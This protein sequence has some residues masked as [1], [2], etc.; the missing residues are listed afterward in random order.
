MDHCTKECRNF[1]ASFER[2][3]IDITLHNSDPIEI[4]TVQGLRMCR[5]VLFLIQSQ[6][7]RSEGN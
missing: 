2:L 3:D 7:W 6:V 5:V 1:D 4:P